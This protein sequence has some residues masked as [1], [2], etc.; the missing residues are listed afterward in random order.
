MYIFRKTL[1][2]FG[3]KTQQMAYVG[4]IGALWFHLFHKV[5]RFFQ[6][7]MGMVWL[8]AQGVDHQYLGAHY[9]F[10]FLLGNRFYIGQIGKTTYAIAKN[11]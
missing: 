6:V 3:M 1:F 4:K 8:Y 2:D 9:L 7:K 11:L 10:K 5:Q